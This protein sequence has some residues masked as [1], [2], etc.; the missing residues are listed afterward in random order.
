MGNAISGPTGPRGRGPS[1]FTQRDVQR[2]MR[3]ARNVGLSARID[4]MPDGRISIVPLI[5]G[6]ATLTAGATGP[7]GF[8]EGATGPNEWDAVL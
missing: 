1:K 2:V 6:A 7:N 5:E 3:A 8:I 4:I